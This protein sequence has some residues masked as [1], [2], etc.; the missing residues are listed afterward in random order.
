MT[1]F[2]WQVLPTDMLY[3]YY[4]GLAIKPAYDLSGATPVGY[5]YPGSPPTINRSLQEAT[6][7][8]HHSFWKSPNLGSI[9]L[10]T[11]A[12]YLTRT[13]FEVPAAPQNAHLTM[14]FAT[15][16]LTLP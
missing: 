5:G 7:G 14:A 3:A 15:L 1:G 6:L 16:R 9:A 2:E 11:Q 8:L 13:P 12:S 4:G 10:M